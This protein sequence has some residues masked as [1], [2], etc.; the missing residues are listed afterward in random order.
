MRKR[1]GNRGGGRRKDEKGKE[2]RKQEFPDNKD[3]RPCTQAKEVRCHFV[4]WQ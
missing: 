1:G 4:I 3:V 2:A